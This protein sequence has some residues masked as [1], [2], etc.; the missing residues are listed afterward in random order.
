MSRQGRRPRNHATWTSDIPGRWFGP[1]RGGAREVD[2]PRSN[3]RARRSIYVST[4]EANVST[5]GMLVVGV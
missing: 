2:L 3:F 1:G 5:F 4:P